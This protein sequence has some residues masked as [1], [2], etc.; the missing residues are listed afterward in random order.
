M[1]CHVISSGLPVLELVFLRYIHG[2]YHSRFMPNV[3][4]LNTVVSVTYIKKLSMLHGTVNILR[5]LGFSAEVHYAVLVY[6]TCHV[7]HQRV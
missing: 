3:Q 7:R 2:F 1:F 4:L 5:F 6:T